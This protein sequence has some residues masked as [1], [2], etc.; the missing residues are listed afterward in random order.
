MFIG[1]H[2][3]SCGPKVDEIEKPSNLISD[4]TL[5]MML[6]DIHM[7]DASFSVSLLRDNDTLTRTFI[8]Q[9]MFEKYARSEDDFNSTLR[10]YTLNEIDKLHKLYDEVLAMLNQKKATS[11]KEKIDSNLDI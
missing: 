8:Y 10:Y 3:T 5:V 9:S 6:F 11:D 2:I 4:D 7:I 1:L